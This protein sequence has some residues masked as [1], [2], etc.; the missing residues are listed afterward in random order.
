MSE[1]PPPPLKKPKLTAT[2][3]AAL[4]ALLQAGVVTIRISIFVTLAYGIMYTVGLTGF[5]APLPVSGLEA[6]TLTIL[7]SV[8][9]CFVSTAI[10]SEMVNPRLKEGQYR[11]AALISLILGS[12]LLLPAPIA[13][14]FM[15]IGS[16]IVILVTE[17]LS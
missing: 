5:I 6:E 9:L 12:I 1:Q 7:A 11:T 14:A 10:L 16:F 4:A 2:W 13:G 3:K 8:I 17:I 15:L